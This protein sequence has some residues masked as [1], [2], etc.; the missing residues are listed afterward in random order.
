ML[1]SSG[2]PTAPVLSVEEALRLVQLAERDLLHDV[3]M[4][5]GTDRPLRVLG[6]S[7]HVDGR[8]VG[9]AGSPPLLGQHT[10]EI[11]A[12]AGFSPAEIGAL[13]AEGVL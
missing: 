6:S 2:V 13:H 10:D 8:S 7:V 11:L 1:A 4:P 5:D 3:P 9:P 12:E